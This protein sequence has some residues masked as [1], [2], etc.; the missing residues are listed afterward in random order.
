MQDLSARTNIHD[1]LTNIVL[2]ESHVSQG[3]FAQAE[4]TLRDA[5]NHYGRAASDLRSEMAGLISGRL[6][7]VRNRIDRT[8]NTTRGRPGTL[9]STAGR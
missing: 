9:A 8:R 4:E 1:A 2:A 6:A 3:R 5:E 7:D